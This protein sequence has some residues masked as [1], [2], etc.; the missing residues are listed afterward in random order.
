MA[1]RAGV[2]GFYP[3]GCS[4][5]PENMEHDFMKRGYLLPGGCKDLIDVLKQSAQPSGQRPVRMLDASMFKH[6]IKCMKLPPIVGEIV[7]P[8]KIPVSQL[9]ALLGQKPF[10][11]IA[12]VTRLGFL[13][14][15][16]QQLS[17]DFS[18]CVAR[19]YGFFAIKAA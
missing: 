5:I 8:E 18:S 15:P 17:F 4:N 12:D 1:A 2:L 13:L 16:E 7:I 14:T 9:A 6:F 11:I 10:K 3:L 19:M